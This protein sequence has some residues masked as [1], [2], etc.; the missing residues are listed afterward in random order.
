MGTPA[1]GPRGGGPASIPPRPWAE[2]ETTEDCSCQGRWGWGWGWGWGA[3]LSWGKLPSLEAARALRGSRGRDPDRPPGTDQTLPRG[4]DT[5]LPPESRGPHTCCSHCQARCGNAGA[6][7][8]RHWSTVFG[9]RIPTDSLSEYRL[10]LRNSASGA[11]GVAAPC[12][13]G[14]TPRGSCPAGGWIPTGGVQEAAH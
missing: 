14:H 11:A 1:Q 13:A 2:G 12:P 8:S 4:L 6:A 10:K 5:L 9:A 7:G 3:P